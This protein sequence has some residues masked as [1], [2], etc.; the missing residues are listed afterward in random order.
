MSM[1]YLLIMS[2]ANYSFWGCIVAGLLAATGIG[3]LIRCLRRKKA[4]KNPHVEVVPEVADNSISGALKPKVGQFA[5]N[6]GALHNIST[7]GNK[8]LNYA[9]GVFTNVANV[10]AMQYGDDVKKWFS[11]FAGDRKS[12]DVSLYISKASELLAIF[13]ECGIASVDEAHIE[14]NTSSLEHYNR[15]EMIDDGETCVVVVPYWTLDGVLVE[16]GIVRRA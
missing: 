9:N 15:L 1:T 12:W 6:F 2:N 5:G 16:K 8:D 10:V 13:R 11:A 14:W 3:L 7:S 4:K